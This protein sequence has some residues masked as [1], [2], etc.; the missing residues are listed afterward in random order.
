MV[1]LHQGIDQLHAAGA[2]LYIIGNGTPNFIAG[3]RE[4]TKYPDPIYV[5]PSLAVYKAAE[6][7]RGALRT[8]DP[9]ALGKTITAF[10][11]GSRQGSVQGDA[12]QQGGVLVVAPGGEVKFHHASDRPGDNASIPEIVAALR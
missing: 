8:F 1:Q 10:R 3:F 5:D 9:R 2:E 12:W 4:Q 11:H 7:K 6:L